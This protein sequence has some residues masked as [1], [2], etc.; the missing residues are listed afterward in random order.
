MYSDET[1]ETTRTLAEL[2][3]VEGVVVRLPG[4]QRDIEVARHA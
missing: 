2:L 4:N 1:V 3:V